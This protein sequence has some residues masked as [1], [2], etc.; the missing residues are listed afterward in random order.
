MTVPTEVSAVVYTGAGSTDTY[1]FTWQIVEDA[2]LIV[3][4]ENAAGTLAPKLVLDTDYT[5]TGAGV[6]TGGEVTLVAGNL[7]SGQRLFIASDPEQIQELLLQ[8]GAAFN[9]A[10][11]MAA[12]DL[13][14]REV[15]ANRRLIGNCLQIPVMESLDGYDLTLPLAADRVDGFIGFGDGGTTV[16]VGSPTETIISAAMI[17]VVQASTTAAAFALLGGLPLSGGT[18]TG[19]IDMDGNAITDLPTPTSDADAA[20]KEY[21]DDS[22]AGSSNFIVGETRIWNTATPPAK[23]LLENGAEVSRSTYADL[24]AVIGTTFG[25]T[26]GSTF[27]LPDSR[28]RVTVGAGTGSGLT[29]RTLAATGGEESHVLS[30][31]EMPAHTHTIP[32]KAGSGDSFIKRDASTSASDKTSGSTGGGSAHNTMQPFLVRYTIICYQA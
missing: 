9:P 6:P 12:L 24:F 25:S 17:P 18:M 3:Y 29:P 22:I 4:Q 13:L 2:D 10:D 31:A 28:G 5:V 21:V 30:I 19:D 7:G 16:V 20:T 32:T 26:S 11:L 15:Q 23:F 1:A 14:T 27:T 8:Q